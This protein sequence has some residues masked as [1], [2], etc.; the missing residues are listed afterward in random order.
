MRLLYSLLLALATPLI[1]GY[2]AVRGLKDRRYLAR[3]SERLGWRPVPAGPYDYHVHAASLGEVN[4]AM[5]LVTA[6]LARE[7]RPRILLTTLTPTGSQRVREVFGDRVTHAYLPLDLAGAMGRLMDRA[8]PAQLVIVETEIWPNLYRAAA[9]HNI[10][11]LMV[12]ARLSRKSLKGY[13][14]FRRLIAPALAGVQAVLAQ[15]ERDAA[16]FIRCGANPERVERTGNLKFDIHLPP[17]LLETGELLRAGWGVD[18]PVLVAG[19]T[20]EGDESVLFQAFQTILARHPRALLVLAPR[21]PERFAR[22]AQDAQASGLT[23]RRRSESRFPGPAQC[24]VLD[25]MGELLDYY[26]A[27]DVA[28]VGGT[29]AEVGGHNLLEPAALGKPLLFGPHTA[30]VKETAT[31]LLESGAARRV[32]TATDVSQVVN[33]LFDH[34]ATRDRMGQAGLD[35]VTRGRGALDRTLAVLDE[36][37]SAPSATP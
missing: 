3:W 26:A 10:P 20:H 35:L 34:P 11:L 5:P 21:H 17:S 8:R 27:A 36:V 15:G 37:S 12:N 28:F 1:L 9:R 24:L 25:T 14:R 30:H 31:R 2:F 16:R 7:P 6:L 22:A 23:V 32:L 29:I 33:P 4:A 13:Q 19:S 18:R